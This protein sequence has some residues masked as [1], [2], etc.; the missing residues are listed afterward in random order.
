[1]ARK[2]AF[3]ERLDRCFLCDRYA[4]DMHHIFGASDKKA[5]ERH[6]FLVPLCA[7]C[8]TIG[9]KAVHSSGGHNRNM[10]LKLMAQNYY[11][12]NIGSRDDFR[13]EFRKS[14]L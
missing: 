6:A 4:T 2:S 12:M 9:P 13:K 1:M 3:A 11:E 7:D 10:E 8:H 5:S 14:Y